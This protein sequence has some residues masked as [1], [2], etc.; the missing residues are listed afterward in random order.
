MTENTIE[1]TN[2]SHLW[3]PGRSGNPAGRP[4]GS[5]NATTLAVQSLLS[6]Q[7]EALTQV[8]IDAALNGDS[9]ALK[10]CLDRILP[11]LK[12]LPVNIKLP[13]MMTAAELPTMTAAIIRAVSSGD[14]LPTEAEKI[15]KLVDVHRNAIEAA[16]FD[17]RLKALEAS[18]EITE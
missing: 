18:Q 16:D 7:A 17:L 3:K 10:I 11:T 1:N 8:A 13:S 2:K 5:R 4:K 6:G 14:L 15:S 9:V 12:E